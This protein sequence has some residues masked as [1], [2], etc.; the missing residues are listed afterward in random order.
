M[1]YYRR[2]ENEKPVRVANPVYRITP[3][4][5]TSSANTSFT[6]SNIE[7]LVDELTMADIQADAAF[8]D[9]VRAVAERLLDLLVT[10]TGGDS[11]ALH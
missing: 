7:R 8:A 1:P 11:E 3:Q 10:S 9:R 2:V 6:L 4:R 5:R